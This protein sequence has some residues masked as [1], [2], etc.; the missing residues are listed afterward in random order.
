ML[1]LHTLLNLTL[2]DGTFEY[3]TDHDLAW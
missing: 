2:F 3:G 1:A